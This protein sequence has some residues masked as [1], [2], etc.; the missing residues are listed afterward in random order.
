MKMKLYACSVIGESLGFATILLGIFSDKDKAKTQAH[1]FMQGIGD[2]FEQ[3]DHGYEADNDETLYYQTKH[4]K[5]RYT[6]Y[7][8]EY[9]LNELSY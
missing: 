5:E 6:F 4:S 1:V 2:L 8:E 3:I 7:I 9:K